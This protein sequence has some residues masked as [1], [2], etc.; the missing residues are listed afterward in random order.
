V[1]VRDDNRLADAAMTSVHCQRCAARVLVRKSSANQT[2][3]QWN[4]E[5]TGRCGER[6][7]LEKLAGHGGNGLFLGCVALSESIVGA[8]RAGDL[9]I[10]DRTSGSPAPAPT[11]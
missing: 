8:V 10:V 5:A 6:R 7:E 2:S 3:V 1:T 11:S 9:S 4:T